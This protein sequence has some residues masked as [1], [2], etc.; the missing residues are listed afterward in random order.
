MIYSMNYNIIPTD[1]FIKE[2]KKL[3]KKYRSIKKDLEK[4]R[5][6]L[7]EDPTLGTHLGNNAYKLRM[8]ITSKGKGKS[9]GARVITY[10]YVQE[11]TVFLMSVYDKSEKDNISDAK[12]KAIIEKIQRLL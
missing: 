1:N 5:K 9:G 8:A 4:L 7:V 10:V 6:S 2:V 11:E 3:A 12:I